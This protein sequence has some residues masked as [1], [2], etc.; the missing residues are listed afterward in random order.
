MPSSSACSGLLAKHCL[1]ATTFAHWRS[2][3][4]PLLPGPYPT[5]VRSGEGHA[6]RAGVPLGRDERSGDGSLLRAER[7]S[8]SLRF[9]R[10]LPQRH[11]KDLSFLYWDAGGVRGRPSDD[12]GYAAKLLDDLATVI[13]V[14]SRRVYA[15][16][17]PTGR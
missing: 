17:I 1:P 13:N 10:R 8:G 7:E 3:A 4:I 5:R 2:P 9:C 12:V 11:R 15:T 6:G 14:D 16:G